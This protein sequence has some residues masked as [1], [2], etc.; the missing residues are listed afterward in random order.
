MECIF[1][2]NLPPDDKNMAELDLKGA[3]SLIHWLK[4]LQIV[5]MVKSVEILG[6]IIQAVPP[7]LQR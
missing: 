3:F 7:K 6:Q 2:V 5:K 4:Y 1:L